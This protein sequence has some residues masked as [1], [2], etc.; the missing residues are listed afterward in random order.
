MTK[1]KAL[2][3]LELLSEG[4]GI[5]TIRKKETVIY[6]RKTNVV[7]RIKQTQGNREYGVESN[8]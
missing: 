8:R 7:E 4:Q 2:G 1:T 3:L 5:Q 6:Q